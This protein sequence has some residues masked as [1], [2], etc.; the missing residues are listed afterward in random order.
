MTQFW[1]AQ[2]FGVGMLTPALTAG[3][4][5]AAAARSVDI[6]THDTTGT[7][8]VASHDAAIQLL[9]EGVFALTPAEKLKIG[10][11]RIRLA[12]EMSRKS[13]RQ[14][15]DVH[16]GQ[17]GAAGARGRVHRSFLSIGCGHHSCHCSAYSGRC[18]SLENSR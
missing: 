11:D 2:I 10:G 16:G 1:K 4:P 12:T 5:H 15:T 13:S 6:D 8:G 14:G 3:L 17:D 18:C 9:Q 7:V